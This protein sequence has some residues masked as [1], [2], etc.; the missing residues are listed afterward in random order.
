MAQ[1]SGPGRIGIPSDWSHAHVVFSQPETF[2]RLRDVQADPRYWQQLH[3]SLSVQHAEAATA[4]ASP[5]AEV[6]WSES[7]ST[8]ALDFANVVTYPAKFSFE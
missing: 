3:R 1:G 2:G 7:V 6:D 5:V 4:G 8:T